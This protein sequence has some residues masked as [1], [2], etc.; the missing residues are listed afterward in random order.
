ME[1][2]KAKIQYSVQRKLMNKATDDRKWRNLRS[3]GKREIEILLPVP[4]STNIL[5]HGHFCFYLGFF[6][7][8]FFTFISLLFHLPV[9]D[10]HRNQTSFF[11][12]LFSPCKLELST[13]TELF[14]IS[15]Y[16]LSF[17]LFLLVLP[18]R[19]KLLIFLLQKLLFCPFLWVVYIAL[20]I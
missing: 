6:F 7:S 14:C 11:L 18:F 3:S 15:L 16:F 5:P 13:W 8:L 9:F 12:L 20:T 17:I 1:E 4:I 19:N 2:E 10:S